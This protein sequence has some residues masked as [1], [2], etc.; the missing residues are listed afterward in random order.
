MIV[1]YFVDIK[2]S[3]WKV[4]EE[5]LPVLEPLAAATEMLTKEDI[6]TG[7]CVHVLITMLLKDDLGAI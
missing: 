7:S 3:T 2:D 1:T 5:I 6:P 4:L